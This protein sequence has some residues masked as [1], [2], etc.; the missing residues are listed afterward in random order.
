MKEYICYDLDTNLPDEGRYLVDCGTLGRLDS[1]RLYRP[2][3]DGL[4]VRISDGAVVSQPVV[5]GLRAI[6]D[7]KLPDTLYRAKWGIA[8]E[9]P[10]SRC[11]LYFE[12]GT[13]IEL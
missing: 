8:G 11:A 12:E 7:D 13:E 2:L 4:F 10:S 6:P 1:R 5:E 9:Y 3:R